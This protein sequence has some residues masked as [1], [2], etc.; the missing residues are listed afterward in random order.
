MSAIFCRHAQTIYNDLDIFQGL[1]DSP[2]TNQGIKKSRK[3]NQFLK[4]NYNIKTFFISDLKRVKETYKIVSEGINAD[5]VVDTRLREICFGCWETKKRVDID[6]I[7]LKER[8]KNRYNFVH[9]GEYNNVEGQSFSSIY[10]IVV[11][12]IMD[13]KNKG[14]LG[15]SIDCC[16]I[17]HQGV[18]INVARFCLDLSLDDMNKLRIK[19][20]T[21]IIVSES[22]SQKFQVKFVDI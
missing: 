6:P 3:L 10:R 18:L 2:L 8:A 1:S 4:Q 17:T 21:I 12:F 15:E 7:I 16:C 20:D 19:N 11:N 13:I 5:L 9:P 22:S 14:F